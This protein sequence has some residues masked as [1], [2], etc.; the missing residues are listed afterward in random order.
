MKPLDAI[1]VG[2]GPA[3]LATS[4]EL[5]RRGVAHV[6]LERGSQAGHTWAN[7]YD[8]L[9]LHT[10]KH[11]S[12]LPGLPFPRST[13]L[14]PTRHDFV[15]YL[16]QYRERFRLPVVTGQDVVRVERATAAWRAQT[17]GGGA[18]SGRALV[19][20]SGIVSNPH[21][22]AVKGRELFR[23]RIT[24]SVEYRRPDGYSGKRVLI[25]GVG[26]SA[27]EIAVELARCGARV[28]VSVRS[29]RRVVPRQI[30]G[31]PVQYI[32]VALAV[33]PRRAQRT[34]TAAVSRISE[35]V[36]GKAVVPPPAD[37]ACPDVPLI[38]LHFADAVR[39]GSVRLV[40]GEIELTECGARFAD[41]SEEPFDE[42]LLATGYRAALNP[43]N[44]IITTDECGFARRRGRV[45]SAEHPD[46]FFVGHNYDLRGA[47]RNISLDANAAARAISRLPPLP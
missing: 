25:V 30:A 22:P 27:G 24:H 23:G 8:S 12:A 3:G 17:R 19:M 21:R 4:R 44:G 37:G 11:L 43:L 14:F 16:Q 26:N 39:D 18:F 32:A 31:L 35:T 34:V 36:R 5:S 9:V 41:G 1:I 40:R 15:D 42:V 13:P 2:A 46:L 29:G 33:L 20:A 47:L 7:L 38:G 45:Q 28:V 10:G 6:V